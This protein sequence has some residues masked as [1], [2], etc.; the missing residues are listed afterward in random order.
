MVSGTRCKSWFKFN[1]VRGS[2]SEGVA[3]RQVRG[4]E[5]KVRDSFQCTK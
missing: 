1:G 2:G 5:N 3:D 4:S